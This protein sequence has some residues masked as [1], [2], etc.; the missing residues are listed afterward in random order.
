MLVSETHPKQSERWHP[1]S[2]D[3]LVSNHSADFFK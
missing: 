2:R 1:G 3:A